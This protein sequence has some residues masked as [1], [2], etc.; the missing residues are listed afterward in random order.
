MEID[1]GEFRKT[2]EN[3]EIKS[4]EQVLLLMDKMEEKE[5]NSITFYHIGGYECLRDGTRE[6]GTVS[7]LEELQDFADDWEI[8]YDKSL[9]FDEL[10]EIVVKDWGERWDDGGGSGWIE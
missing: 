1:V 10:L 4:V 6:D 7:T 9:N 2:V 3:L 8:D 5:D